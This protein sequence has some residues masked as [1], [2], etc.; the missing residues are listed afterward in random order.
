M[1]GPLPHVCIPTA[2]HDQLQRVEV[3]ARAIIAHM[4]ECHGR[5]ERIPAEEFD[6][7]T[8]PAHWHPGGIMLGT[9]P[10]MAL[11]V[12]L[13]VIDAPDERKSGEG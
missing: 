6:G 9:T 11:A 10:L 13:G 7:F 4:F 2:R 8:L 12:A 3:A 1:T 5:F